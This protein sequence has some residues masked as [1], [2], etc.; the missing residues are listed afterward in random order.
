VYSA[1]MWATTPVTVFPLLAIIVMCFLVES[2]GAQSGSVVALSGNHPREIS[3]LQPVGRANPV[4]QLNL[5]VN[6]ALRNRS[7]LDQLLRNQQNPASP[8][9]H[10]WLTPAQFDARFGPSQQDVNAVSQWLKAQGFQV[11]A[12]SL[13]QRYVRFT[14][15]VADAERAFSTSIMAFGDGTSYSNITDP[16]IPAGLAGVVGSVTGLDNFI[17]SMPASVAPPNPSGQGDAELLNPPGLLDPGPASSVPESGPAIAT[18]G[19]DI[20]GVISFGPSDFRSFYD[21][22]PLIGSGATGAG[23]DCLAIVGTSNFSASAVSLFNST[24]DLPASSITTILT[25][26]VDPGANGAENEAFLDLEWSHAVAPGATHRFYLGNDATASPNGSIIDSIQRAVNDN[27]CGVIS[28]SFAMCGASSSF[29]TTV[30]S[31]IYAQ[32][33]AQGQSVFIISGDWG[34][35]GLAYDATT[36]SCVV[37]STRTPNELGTDPN[38]TNVGGTAFTPNFVGGNNVGDVPESAWNDSIAHPG[39]GATGGGVSGIYSKPS[40]QIGPGVPN[41]GMRDFPDV[42]IIASPYSPGVFWG[43]TDSYGSPVISCCIGGTSLSAPVWAGIAKLLAQLS[44]GRTGSLNPRIYALAN[45]AAAASGFRDVTVGNNNFNGVAGFS[46]GPGFDQTSGWGS[47]DISTFGN[48]WVS[49]PATPAI[50][51]IP[52]VIQ[53]GSSFNISGNS[54]SPGAKVNFFVATSSGPVN[55]GPL[56]PSSYSPTLLTVPVPATVPLG[57]GFVS[58]QVVN[59]DLGYRAS[60]VAS[61]LLQGSAAAGIPTITS[62]NGVGLAPTSSNPAYATNNVQT[63]LTQGSSVTLGGSGFDTT[64]GVAVLVYCACTGGRMPTILIGPGGFTS[65]SLT[66]TLP[67]TTPTGPLSLVVVNSGPGGGYSKSS[68]AVSVVAGATISITSVTQSGS[69]ITVKGTGFST[70]TVINLFNTQ[71]GSVVNLGGFAAGGVPKIPLTVSS[72]TMFTFSRPAAAMS[73]ASYVQAFN[74]PFVPYTSSGSGPGGAFTL[75]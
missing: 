14:A 51:S 30:V 5:Q 72:S 3:G 75:F 64:N 18:P 4:A 17:H 59:A 66:F 20:G 26:G 2:A 57:N 71:G 31:P 15:T 19:V 44:A 37:A 65:S 43:N 11:T 10:R 29:Y 32:A 27:A 39:G 48:S 38:V 21:E 68:N 60:N 62:I 63:V 53:V 9:Y 70:L 33:A 54:F 49:P 1:R 55:A 58:V 41:D 52:S 56:T 42:A 34:A 13:A 12:T 74:P 47:V 23:G 7:A 67:S 35:A 24:F 73:G 45:T 6:L 50:S 46:A 16:L 28:V 36:N 22:N 8:D 25:D 40:Y 61:A 69:T